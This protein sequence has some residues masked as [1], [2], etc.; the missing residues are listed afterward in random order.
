LYGRSASKLGKNL[1][2]GLG[3]W[4][5]DRAA[6]GALVSSATEFLGHVRY[7]HFAFAA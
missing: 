3:K 7:V 2:D 4:A 6:T 5:I 1:A